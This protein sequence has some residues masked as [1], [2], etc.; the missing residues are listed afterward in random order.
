LKPLACLWAEGVR[1]RQSLAVA[2]KRKE[3][4]RFRIGTRV[5]GGLGD[6]FQ[7]DRSVEARICGADGS[8][9]RISKDDARNG[10]IVGLAWLAQDIRRSNFG[11]VLADMRQLPNA[12]DV[13]H[14]P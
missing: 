3:S 5:G 6:I 2:Q 4:V 8:S 12:G 14:G 10:V 11:L 1:S 7:C 13:A 9:L